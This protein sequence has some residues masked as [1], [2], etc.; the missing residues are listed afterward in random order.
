MSA[1]SGTRRSMKEL[2]DGTVRVQIDIDPQFRDQFF[3]AFGQ[4]DMP[5]ALA[6]L[7]ADFEQN[8]PETD[9]RW[10][11]ALYKSGWW[12]NPKVLAALGTDDE[13]RAWI[14]R[15]PSAYSGLFSE[16]VNGEGRCI[17]AHVRRAGESGMGYKAGYACIPL[18]DAEHQQQHRDGESAL[19]GQAW[20]DGRRAHYVQQWAHERLRTALGVESLKQASPVRFCDWAESRG[21]TT[22]L[23]LALRG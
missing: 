3:A 20:F 4:I 5:V 15:Q 17:A 22:T 21:L 2:S 6:P 7:A 9:G 13:Y 14:Q 19:G 12:F 23:P 16:Y 10:V 8:M 1:I 11:S 18:T